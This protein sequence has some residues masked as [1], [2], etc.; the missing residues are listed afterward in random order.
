V[1]VTDDGAG[2]R[3]DD[4]ARIFEPY[5][6]ASRET[7]QPGSVGLGL[8]VSRKLA[9]LMAGDVTYQRVGDETVFE[10]SLPNAVGRDAR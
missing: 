9:N 7:V 4:A 10:L 3:V 5:Y 1:T 8:A 2:L 6:R